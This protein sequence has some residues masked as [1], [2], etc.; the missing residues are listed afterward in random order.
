MMCTEIKQGKSQQLSQLLQISLQKIL[1]VTDQCDDSMQS[2]SFKLQTFERK[3]AKFCCSNMTNVQLY[4][5]SNKQCIHTMLTSIS[6][7]KV[8][9]DNVEFLPGCDWGN[10]LDRWHS[11]TFMT[12]IGQVKK[13]ILHIP[14]VQWVFLVGELYMTIISQVYWV[15]IINIYLCLHNWKALNV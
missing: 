4:L 7:H 13:L 3:K 1:L 8:A 11:K 5:C 2:L 10:G 9:P 6:K 14:Y 12:I 15:S